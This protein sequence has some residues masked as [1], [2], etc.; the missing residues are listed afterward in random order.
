MWAIGSRGLLYD[1][2]WLIVN[3]SGVPLT[4]KREPRLCQLKPNIDISNRRLVLSME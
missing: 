3:S 1:R 2:D 4:Q